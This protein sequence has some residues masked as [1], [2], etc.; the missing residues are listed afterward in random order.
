VVPGSPEHRDESGPGVAAHVHGAAI[1]QV[2]TFISRQEQTMAKKKD[3]PA[4][5]DVKGGKGSYKNL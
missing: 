1:G 5:K 2:G 3:L 4:K